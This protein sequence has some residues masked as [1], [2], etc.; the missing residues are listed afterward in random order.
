[1]KLSKIKELLPS[2]S[3]VEFQLEDGTPVPKHFH[4][5]EVG[6]MDKHF[7]DCGGVVRKE[8]KVNFQLWNAEDTS[9]RLMPTKLLK[10]IELSEDKL[11]L[12]DGE[13]EV[14]YQRDTIGKFDLAFTGKTFVLLSKQTA[15]LASDACGIPQEKPKK[16]LSDLQS[17]PVC[18]PNSGCC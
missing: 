13:I 17:S 18:T 6:G 3:H 4:I 14:E 11:G 16:K 7:I 2:L 10:I 5:T 9:H 12:K 8:Y 1:M 15:C